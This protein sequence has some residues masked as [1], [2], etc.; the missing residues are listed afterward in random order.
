[1][2][3]YDLLLTGGHLIDPSQKLMASKMLVL[4]T[5]EWLKLTTS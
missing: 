1:M 5:G 2:N 4:K 3:R